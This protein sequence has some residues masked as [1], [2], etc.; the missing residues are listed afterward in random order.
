MRAAT[1]ACGQTSLFENFAA[2]GTLFGRVIEEERK[3]NLTNMRQVTPEPITAPHPHHQAGHA[4][5]RHA[6]AA[7]APAASVAHP[8]RVNTA[9]TPADVNTL[10]STIQQEFP[11]AH[12]RVTGR[13]RTVQRQ[14][15]LMA[16]RRLGNRAQFLRVYLPATHITEMDNWVTAH[17]NATP[18][19]TSAAFAEI[20]T[21]AQARGATVSNHLTDRARDISIPMGSHV[22]QHE[23]RNRLQQLGA[24]VIDERDA[25]GGAHWHVDY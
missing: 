18:A 15:E 13:G 4:A 6:G 22:T 23:V 5:A 2:F 11:D 16:A 10:I 12:I 3:S 19:E 14:A 9:A 7:A 20:I 21:R 8:A 25:V 17:A 24:H 1:I